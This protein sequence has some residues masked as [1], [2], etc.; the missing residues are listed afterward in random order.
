MRMIHALIVRRTTANA[1]PLRARDGRLRQDRNRPPEEDAMGPFPHDAPPAKIT[2]EN[3]AGTD[4]F[5][6]VEFAHPEPDKLREL[7]TRMGYTHVANHKTKAVDEFLAQHLNVRLHYTPTYASWLNQVERSFGLI[8]LRAI[9]RGSFR[10]VR[11][12]VKPI[13]TFVQHYNT[14]RRPFIW[15]ATADSIM[16]KVQRLCERING[17]HH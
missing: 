3:P 5:E 13:D 6:F 8:T 14:H 17:T 7:F 2:A 12:L 9:R 4:G 11:E 16:A 1:S 15:T 10:T